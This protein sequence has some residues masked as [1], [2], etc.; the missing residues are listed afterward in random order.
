MGGGSNKKN[1]IIQNFEEEISF[2]LRSDKKTNVS[3]NRNKNE[4]FYVF[5]Q[6]ATEIVL[7]MKNDEKLEIS[8]EK[9]KLKR[10][11]VIDR[12]MLHVHEKTDKDYFAFHHKQK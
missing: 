4:L 10:K 1:C 8:T 2:F 6:S 12:N 9:H 11:N 3:R 5:L 7:G